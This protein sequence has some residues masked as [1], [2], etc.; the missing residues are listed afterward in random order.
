MT[1]EVL[2]NMLL[3][4]T[5]I[6]FGMLTLWFVMFT[7]AGGWVYRKHSKWF[8]MSREAFNAMHYAGMG[9]FKLAIF[10]FNLVPWLALLIVG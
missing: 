8:P 6:N 1:I 7:L 2:R 5:I 3:W 9:L 4:C 10:V